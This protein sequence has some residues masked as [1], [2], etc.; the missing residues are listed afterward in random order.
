MIHEIIN[1]Y[2]AFSWFG[3]GIIPM[4]ATIVLII[5]RN[6]EITLGGFLFSLLILGT[7]FIG[8][9][10]FIVI[11]LLLGTSVVLKLA[12]KI[13]LFRLKK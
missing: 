12:D 10:G 1:L 13:V 4:V 5:N 9:I 8:L 11:I 6:K 7:G 2:P 3:C